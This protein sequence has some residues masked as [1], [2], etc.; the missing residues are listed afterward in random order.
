MVE[1]GL[2]TILWQ[3][4]FAL[5]ATRI[6]ASYDGKEGEVADNIGY[7]EGNQH[8]RDMCRRK[9]PL[10]EDVAIAFEE[11]EDE[12]VREATKEGET[13]RWAQT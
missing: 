11:A 6:I 2:E 12:C 1:Q 8:E 7:S 10:F 5:R 4:Y 9:A 13:G 3:E